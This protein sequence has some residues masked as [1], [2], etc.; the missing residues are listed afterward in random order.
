MSRKERQ[1]R[2]GERTRVIRASFRL[3]VGQAVAVPS[4]EP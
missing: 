4:M 1:V 3:V 2:A